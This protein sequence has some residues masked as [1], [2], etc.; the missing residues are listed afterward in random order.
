M[1]VLENQHIRFAGAG[2]FYTDRDWIHAERVETTFEII[3]VVKGEVYL[4]EDG[5]DIHIGAGQ[6]ALLEPGVCH[7]GTRITRDVSFYWVHFA[8]L[9]GELP[10][11]KRF[12]EWFESKA[13]FKELLHWSNLPAPPDFLINA[14]LIRILSEFCYIEQQEKHGYDPRAEAVKE[15]IRIHADAGQ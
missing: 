7:K 11:Q 12:F 4:E 6:L 8:L 14:T 3:Y 9:S 13:L 2:L 15:W 5:R 10:F 1:N